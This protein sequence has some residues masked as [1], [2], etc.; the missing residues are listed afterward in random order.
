MTD[1][2]DFEGS[3]S[4]KIAAALA[5]VVS[6]PDRC[7]VISKRKADQNSVRDYWL[8]DEAI[9]L[10]E[11]IELIIDDCT[12]KLSDRSRDNFIRS[13]NCGS[14]ISE[15]KTA[16]RIRITGKG[17]AVLEGA[18]HPR[19]TGDAKKQ[20]GVRTY[21]TDAG[22]EDEKQTGDWRNVG[23][24]LAKTE[25]FSISNLTIRNY[26]CWGI[27]LEKCAY[28]RVENIRF[29]T[30]E[31]RM[32][33][34]V[35]Q[36]VLN[37][38]GL[39]LRKGCHHIEVENITGRTGDDL[40][41]L[42]AIHPEIKEVGTLIYTELSGC[43]E[44][45]NSNDIHDIHL[46]HIHGYSTGGHQIVRL[47]NACGLKIHDIELEDV[48]DTS[49]EDPEKITDAVAVKIGDDLPA[50]GGVAPLGDT[51]RI[52]VRK[53]ESRAKRCV[54]IAGSLCDAVIA[55]IINH[56]PGCKPVECTSGEENLA[57]VSISDTRPIA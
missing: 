21:G 25:D 38:D 7:V 29:E 23:I 51:A 3:D 19:S 5:K 32:I 42:T 10:P 28:G 41:A 9:L 14:G 33:D 35:E 39:D 30:R 54:L 4:Q 46:K 34:G 55:D 6:G 50:W 18:D 56:N 40:V 26:H 17:N 22:K 52:T 53:V 44:P 12:I 15:I 36:M 2:N 57:R 31:K 8:I 37:Q 11:D 16:R 48:R 1:P 24:L 49:E 20:L 45:M 13:S 43:P 47:L 27:S